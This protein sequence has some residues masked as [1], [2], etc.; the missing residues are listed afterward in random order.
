MTLGKRLVNLIQKWAAELGISDY[1]FDFHLLSD[2]EMSGDYAKV[3]TDDVTREVEIDF[4]KHRLTRE[5]QEIERT[6][7]HELL[8]VRFNEYSELMNDLIHTYVLSPKTRKLLKKQAEKLEH[9][10][11]VAITDSLSKEKA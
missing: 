6:V 5:P 7:V 9:K 3:D 10:I 1:K 4:N 2:R 8:H 11:V